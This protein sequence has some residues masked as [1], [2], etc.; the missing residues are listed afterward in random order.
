MKVTAIRRSQDRPTTADRRT[1]LPSSI[2][3]QGNDAQYDRQVQ[4]DSLHKRKAPLVTIW[5]ASY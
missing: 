2:P 4:V 3:Q 5:A 1:E